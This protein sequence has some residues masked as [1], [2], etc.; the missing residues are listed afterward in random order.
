[1]AHARTIAVFHFALRH[2][3]NPSTL[4]LAC[5]VLTTSPD[6]QL[7]ASLS[8]APHVGRGRAACYARLPRVAAVGVLIAWSVIRLYATAFPR[9]T[10]CGI[11]CKRC[12]IIVAAIHIIIARDHID[13]RAARN[14][15][16]LAAGSGKG[17]S[18]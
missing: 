7:L 10:R 16:E 3:A 5:P 18:G 1:M 8:V 2:V 11:A 17:A 14:G 13:R 4:G 15:R 12:S 9:A 6:Q